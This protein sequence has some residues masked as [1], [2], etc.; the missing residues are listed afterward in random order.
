MVKNHYCALGTSLNIFTVTVATIHVRVYSWAPTLDGIGIR[1]FSTEVF[2]IVIYLYIHV[3]IFNQIMLVSRDSVFTVAL[4][5]NE[6]VEGQVEAMTIATGNKLFVSPL[7]S[8]FFLIFW[9]CL[10]LDNI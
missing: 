6:T 5:C 1:H 9:F 7:S 8:I 3:I 10:T 2:I 4:Q